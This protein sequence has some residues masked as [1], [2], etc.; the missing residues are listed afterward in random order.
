MA[1]HELSG[2]PGGTQDGNVDRLPGHW[3]VGWWIRVSRFLG[4]RG[5]G[6]MFFGDLS[7]D[8]QSTHTHKGLDNQW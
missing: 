4:C 7:A 2:G 8:Q 1:D 3:C 5:R 6:G